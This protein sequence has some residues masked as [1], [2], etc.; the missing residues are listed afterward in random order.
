MSESQAVTW[1]EGLSALAAVITPIAVV[2]LGLLVNKRLKQVEEQQWRGRALIEARL[3][4][5]TELA[6]DLNDLLCFFT[7][8][9]GWKEL[10]PPSIVSL[11]RTIDRKFHLYQPFF[12]EKSATSYS[13]FMNCCFRTFG[14]WGADAHLRTGFGRRKEALGD[15]WDDNWNQLFEYSEETP[16]SADALREIRMRYVDLVAQLVDDIQLTNSRPDYVSARISLN[17]H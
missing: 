7:F 1:V 2:A 11:K 15:E 8:I 3:N 6:G 9:G 12:S 10:T 16:I 5:Y 4:Y 13:E 14:D 17:A